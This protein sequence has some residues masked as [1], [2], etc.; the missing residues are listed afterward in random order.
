M[1]YREGENIIEQGTEGNTFYIIKTGAAKVMVETDGG[2]P[3][4]VNQ[5][6]AG[7]H[8]GETALLK[9]DKRNATITTI[10]P[11]ECFVLSR[12]DFTKAFG[13][14]K[15]IMERE[16]VE[17]EAE[18]DEAVL[19][20]SREDIKFEDLEVVAVLGSGTFGRVKLVKSKSSGEAFA[21]KTMHKSEIVAHRQQQNVM[22]EKNIMVLSNHPFILRL[23]NT[24]KDPHRL[25]MLLEFV[26][27]GELFSVL[28]TA[29]SD[30][31]PVKQA[32]FYAACTV[33]GLGYLH[34]KMIAYRDLKPENLMVDRTGYI[35]IVDFGFAKVR[36][37]KRRRREK[38]RGE[39]RAERSADRARLPAD[40]EEQE[41]RRGQDVHALRH[42]RI[43]R[44]R[45][46]AR[47]RPQ[48]ERRL[49]GAR[50]PHLR[51]DRGLLAVL[52]SSQHGAGHH[53][54]KHRQRPPLV[55]EQV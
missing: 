23:Y 13:A 52:G 24:Y 7:G 16:A 30:G 27:G 11:T 25:H 53:L 15:D 50:R 48:A 40:F 28:H 49:V 29:S 55:P 33:M 21:L 22:H 3:T 46:R 1:Q 51:D 47:P 26:Q 17:R 14:L 20:A 2:A 18:L 10:E 38:A 34:S 44:A 6:K 39:V 5:I 19:K 8:F 37:V 35:K 9:S 31:V 36:R 42:A 32:K 43:P 4:E 45:D 12:E 54:P 41:R